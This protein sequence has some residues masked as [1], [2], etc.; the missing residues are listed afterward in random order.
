L[1]PLAGI[2]KLSR[3]V[4]RKTMPEPAGAG[5]RRMETGAPECRPMP[6]RSMEERMVCSG[7]GFWGKE[8]G[9]VENPQTRV[10]RVCGF[11]V[12]QIYHS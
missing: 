9:S 12:W 5:T 2:S 10:A 1:R 4:R 8:A 3:S 11:G 6:R 7:W